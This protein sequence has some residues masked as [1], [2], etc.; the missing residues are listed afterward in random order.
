M[1][2]S[3]GVEAKGSE[4]ARWETGGHGGDF[5][6]VSVACMGW[7]LTHEDHGSWAMEEASEAHC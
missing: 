1:K 6:V 5:K 7:R 4:K 2:P 3:R